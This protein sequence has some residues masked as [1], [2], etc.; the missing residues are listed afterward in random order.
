MPHM[1]NS[2]QLG[3]RFIQPA[4]ALGKLEAEP[5]VQPKR[6]QPKS[7]S[8][9][10]CVL[11][12]PDSALGAALSSLTQRSLGGRPPSPQSWLQEEGA[13]AVPRR[14]SGLSPRKSARQDLQSDLRT[15]KQGLQCSKE[16]ERG[17]GKRESRGDRATAA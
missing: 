9:C 15:E 11:A 8:H 16:K 7:G 14:E 3:L 6:P 12:E 1:W 13:M 17:E 5:R 10:L 4:T 2:V